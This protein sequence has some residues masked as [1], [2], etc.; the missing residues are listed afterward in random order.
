MIG[1]ERAAL[2][3][4]IASLNNADSSGFSALR[5]NKV[6]PKARSTPPRPG[7]HTRENARQSPQPPPPRHEQHRGSLGALNVTTQQFTD[8][9]EA[10]A[11]AFRLLEDTVRDE[12]AH[13]PAQ[14][15]P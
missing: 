1:V 15:G 7:P 6:F 9:V 11:I 13:E 12:R 3:E 10:K 8:D 5:S 14:G 4:A 2:S